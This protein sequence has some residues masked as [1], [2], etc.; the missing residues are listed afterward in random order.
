MAARAA[1][2]K[3]A[4][5]VVV[6]E[7]GEVLVVADEFVIA[8]A[9]NDRLVKAIVDDVERL[10]AE[11][12]FAKPLRVEGL[13]DRHWVLMDYGDVVVHVFLDETRD[14]YELERLWVEA[15]LYERDLPQLRAGAPA[16]L[17]AEG[18]PKERFTAELLRAGQAV[19]RVTRTSRSLFLLEN[20]GKRLKPGMSVELEVAVG[21]PQRGLAVPRSA[22]VEEE[23]CT[24]PAVALAAAV[25]MPDPTFGER[26][27]VYAELRPGG[28]LTLED[29]A[30]HLAAREVGKELLPERLV[31]LPELPRASGGKIAKAE[32]REDARR[33]AQGGVA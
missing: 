30:A 22:L 17:R 9:P 26:V 31:V 11:A 33:R 27:C 2:A 10:V 4:R 21:Q 28:T 15:E 16:L 20:P 29:L 18:Y 5:D 23:V 19:N 13:D 32:L 7:V 8:S 12:G 14:Y 24:H 25:A 3:G 1:D 6:L